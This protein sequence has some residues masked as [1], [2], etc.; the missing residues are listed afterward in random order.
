MVEKFNRENLDISHGLEVR[1][2]DVMAS[3]D[4]QEDTVNEEQE[5]LDVQVLAP[6]KA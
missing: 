5:G 6:G 4:V 1:D 3:G 2:R